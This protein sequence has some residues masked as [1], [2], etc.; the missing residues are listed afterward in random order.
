MA[1]RSRRLDV[2]TLRTLPL[3]SE[4]FGA[5]GMFTPVFSAVRDALKTEPLLPAFPSG[6][7]AA[8]KA[9]LCRTQEL[10]ELLEPAQLGKLLGRNDELNWLSGDI[11][12]DRTPELRQYLMSELKVI[13]LT[14]EAMIAR[15]D[16]DFLSAIRR[17]DRE[18]LWVPAWPTDV[19][20][21][22]AICRRA[23]C[24]P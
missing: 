10:R 8:D 19:A 13:E 23:A 18:T 22:A 16:S 1:P 7:V 14:R 12:Q 3:N 21:P 15:L 24:P 11:T 4:I 2:A 9:R 6:Y 17:L 5:N 20:A